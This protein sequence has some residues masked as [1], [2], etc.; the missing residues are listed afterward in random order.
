MPTPQATTADATIIRRVLAGDV[1]AFALI[2]DRYHARCLRVATHLLGDSDD[3]EDAVQDAFVRAY[4]HLGSYRPRDVGVDNAGGESGGDGAFGAWLLRILVNQCRTRS[5]RMSR[6]ARFDAEPSEQIEGGAAEPTAAT[7]HEAAERRTDLAQA[8]ALLSPE[9]REAV[10][11]RF[12]D[13]LSYDEMAS[14]TGVGVSALKMRVQRACTRLRALLA[15][16]LH[17]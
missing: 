2:V 16:H 14:I 13:E 1:N 3:A 9:H 6:Y 5:A 11:L 7:D 15:E 17:A 4:R 8:L 12:A 10:V